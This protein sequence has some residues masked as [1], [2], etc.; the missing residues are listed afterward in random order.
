MLI[1]L[2]LLLAESC[3][4]KHALGWCGLGGTTDPGLTPQGQGLITNPLIL[5]ERRQCSETTLVLD[6]LALA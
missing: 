5:Y 6:F 3:R 1:R 2:G 4:N